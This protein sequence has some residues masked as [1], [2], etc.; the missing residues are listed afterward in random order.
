MRT[1]DIFKMNHTLNFSENGMKK[2]GIN[3]LNVITKKKLRTIEKNYF[4]KKS[5]I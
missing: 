4:S 1:R 2:N 3:T 5:E